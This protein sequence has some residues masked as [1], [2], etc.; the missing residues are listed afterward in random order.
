MRI[1][2]PQV[3]RFLTKDVPPRVV[4]R[5]REFKLLNESDFSREV[6][7]RIARF[8]KQD[9][10]PTRLT[11]TNCL[12][13]QPSKTYPDIT[14]RKRNKPWVIVELKEKRKLDTR[15]LESEK[16]KMQRQHRILGTKRGYFVY[17]ARYGKHRLLR[18]KEEY[19]YWF[20]EVPITLERNANMTP[21]EVQLWEKKFRSANKYKGR[22]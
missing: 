3:H 14:I 7:N 9:D 8:L 4:T 18:N 22:D 6:T 10:D 5:F 16:S 12:Y 11:V 1:G 21:E 17:L 13:H 20:Y 19:G 2:I 15:T